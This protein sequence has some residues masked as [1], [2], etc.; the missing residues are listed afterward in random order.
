MAWLAARRWAGHGLA[1]I[2]ALALLV[3]VLSSPIWLVPV[4]LGVAMGSGRDNVSLQSAHPSPSAHRQAAWF[5]R[6]GGGAAGWCRSVVVIAAGDRATWPLPST[7]LPGEPV[8]SAR[9]SMNPHIV[10]VDDRT[11]S[12]EVQAQSAGGAGRLQ[13]HV[14]FKPRSSDGEFTIRVRLK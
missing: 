10:W 2:G 7:D 5:F 3:I 9:C 11:L 6:S 4:A 8:F 1:A 12:I 13:E 14:S